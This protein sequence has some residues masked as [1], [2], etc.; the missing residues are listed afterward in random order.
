MLIQVGWFVWW[1]FEGGNKNREF[2]NQGVKASTL[3]LDS[4]NWIDLEG[5]EYLKHVVE[6]MKKYGK[7]GHAIA[8]AGYEPAFAY[9]EGRHEKS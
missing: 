6:S 3:D 8:D 7:W 5:E 4:E 2:Y 1:N 9:D